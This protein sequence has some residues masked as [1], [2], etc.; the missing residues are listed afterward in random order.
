MTYEIK[1][2][3][4]AIKTK[5]YASERHLLKLN[6]VDRIVTRFIWDQ[7]KGKKEKREKKNSFIDVQQNI[8]YFF[9]VIKRNEIFGDC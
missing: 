8:G 3:I 5:Q 9:V 1:F 6:Y 7:K 2:K 4:G